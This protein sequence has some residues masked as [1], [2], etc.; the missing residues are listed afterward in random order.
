MEEKTLKK[1]FIE[2]LNKK[3]VCFDE[4]RDYID[5]TFEVVF[6]AVQALIIRL[7]NQQ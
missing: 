5:D 7:N 4:K 6:E 2:E 3:V 1:L